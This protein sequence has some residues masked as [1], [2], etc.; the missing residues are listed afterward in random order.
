MATLT[1]NTELPLTEREK[2]I[3]RILLDEPAVEAAPAPKKDSP[4]RQAKAKKTTAAKA[5][6]TDDP[7]F[8]T[9]DEDEKTDSDGDELV[10]KAVKVARA[11]VR[12]GD[13][14]TVQKGLEAAE[15][16]RVSEMTPEQA[17]KF[18]EAVQ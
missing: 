8:D 9:S 4:K 1:I 17:R 10:K 15:A 13:A 7:P 5:Q 2:A 12:D 18:L 3:L 16:G 11:L 6:K 14:A